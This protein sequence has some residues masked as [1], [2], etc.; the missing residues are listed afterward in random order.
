[1]HIIPSHMKRDINTPTLEDS[2]KMYI[3]HSNIPLII[4][5]HGQDGTSDFGNHVVTLDYRGYGDSSGTPT[6]RGVVEDVVNLFKLIRNILPDNPITI[7]GHSMGTGVALLTIDYLLKNLKDYKQPSGLVLE[8]PFYD[9]IEGVK[10]YPLSRILKLNPFFMDAAMDALKN[11][12]LD[13][14][15]HKLISTLP[16]PIVMLH[17]EDDLIIPYYHATL[18]EDYVKMHR[19]SSLPPVK[20]ITIPKLARCGHNHIYSYP[21]FKQV[22]STRYR[23]IHLYR[24]KHTIVLLILGSLVGIYLLIS[25]LFPLLLIIYP[26]IMNRIVFANFLTT[27]NNLRRPENLGLERVYNFYLDVEPGVRLGIWHFRS[28]LVQDQDFIDD[29]DYFS[30]HFLS[31]TDENGQLIPVILYMHGNAFDRAQSSRR[32]LCSRLRDE[33]KYHVFA[34]DYRGYGDSTSHPSERGL[35]KDSRTIY[36]FL[37]QFHN[38]RQRIYLHGHSLGSAVACQLAARLSD[39]ESASLAGIVMEA[40]FINIQDALQ[41]HWAALPFRW[42][43]WFYYLTNR[44][45]KR[46][47]LKFDTKFHLSSVNCPVIILHA[48]DDWIVP[49]RHGVH[50]VQTGIA[51]RQENRKN[52]KLPKFKIDMISFHK[53]GYGHRLIYT[54]PNLIQSLKRLT[55]DEDLSE[56]T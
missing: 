32:E 34:F 45:L 12:S 6:V 33:L 9:T 47:A 21:K 1:M 8:A 19:N 26:R 18:I 54:A 55:Y 5:L 30:K 50:L 7:W 3:E 35:L 52:S 17:A 53:Q 11:V 40:P 31:Q 20:L 43:P 16:L 39:D 46:S 56:E 24:Y 22:V 15:N 42:Q 23:D 2:L 27:F 41:T 38:G 49:Y 36:D 48:D 51:I 13:F 37:Y 4:Y 25:I 44:A 14:P 29:D 28:P 10:S